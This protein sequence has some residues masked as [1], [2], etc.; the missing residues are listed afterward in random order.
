[1]MYHW[2]QWSTKTPPSSGNVLNL[3][4]SYQGWDEVTNYN[5]SSQLNIMGR[6]TFSSATAASSIIAASAGPQSLARQFDVTPANN[7]GNYDA[8]STVPPSNGAWTGASATTLANARLSISRDFK[9][10][11]VIKIGQTVNY[12]TGWKLYPSATSTNPTT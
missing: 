9:S 12:L 11:P 10:E 8:K 7:K 1:M 2:V 6:F 5:I 4:V 3:W